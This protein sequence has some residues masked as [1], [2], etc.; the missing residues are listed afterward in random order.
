MR[1]P[2][3]FTQC[4]RPFHSLALED[5]P[6]QV[7]HL[8][9]SLPSN[10]AS[11]ELDNHNLRPQTHR[12]GQTSHHLGRRHHVHRALSHRPVRA[13]RYRTRKGAAS[14]PY[15]RRAVPR[16]VGRTCRGEGTIGHVAAAGRGASAG[17]GRV[18]SVVT[19]AGV[20]AGGIGWAP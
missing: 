3:P 16:F 18:V 19:A 5:S 9:S 4:R 10:Y 6:P 11:H 13:P 20:Y 8:S 1:P 12:L 7:P 2:P 14:S 15:C 17:G